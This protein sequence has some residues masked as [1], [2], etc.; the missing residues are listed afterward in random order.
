MCS[1]GMSSRRS[2]GGKLKF[3]FE[4]IP[5]L[6]DVKNQHYSW[7]DLT[8]KQTHKSEIRQTSLSETS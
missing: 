3:F 2:F 6:R 8:H 7:H 4:L 5:I 1:S